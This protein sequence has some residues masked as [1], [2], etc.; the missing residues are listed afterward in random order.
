MSLIAT[1]CLLATPA[2]AEPVFR[3]NYAEAIEW[4]EHEET[5]LLLY[6]TASW[7][8]PCR[9]MQADTLVDE[10]VVAQIRRFA[11]VK[12]DIDEFPTLARQY[13]VNG[14][15]QFIVATPSR[16]VVKFTLGYQ[17]A[18]P[19]AQ[20]LE[21]QHDAAANEWGRALAIHE[22]LAAIQQAVDF[23][24]PEE[25]T[26]ALTQLYAMIAERDPEL[27]RTAQSFLNHVAA[28]RPQLLAQGRRHPD[29]LVRLA[30]A[31]ALEEAGAQSFDP[32]KAP[33]DPNRRDR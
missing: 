20:W 27:N 33:T 18:A 2:A 9:Q 16:E 15:P 8:G 10:S 1:I 13:Q 30:V 21:T 31:R 25:T 6:F 14:V 17:S 7:C 19:F 28:T 24:Q 4:A 12:I 11:A 23:G 29:L 5:P 22:E 32:W 3:D 26:D